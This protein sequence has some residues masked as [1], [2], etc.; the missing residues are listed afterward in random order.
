[1]EEARFSPPAKPVGARPP[2]VRYTHDAL[3]DEVIKN[4][5][6]SQNELAAVFGYTSS[7]ISTIMTSDA[8][9]ARLAERRAELVDPAIAASIEH[10]FR[11]MCSRT[12]AVLEEKLNRPAVE[13]P[14]QLA[15]QALQITSRAAGFGARDQT[16]PTPPVAVHLHLE[17]MAGNL[18]KLLRRERAAIEQTSG[19][20]SHD[21]ET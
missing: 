19:D 21:P 11:A 3:I 12:L 5:A 9:L 13:I 10:R 20:P 18:T 16:P 6:V 14:D 8:W 7:W 2:K 1:M 15:L 17:T 4:P